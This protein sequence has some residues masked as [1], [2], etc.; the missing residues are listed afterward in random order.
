MPE[1]VNAQNVWVINTCFSVVQHIFGFSWGLMGW[2][3][4]NGRGVG[5]AR[6]FTTWTSLINASNASSKHINSIA[7]GNK[8]EYFWILFCEYFW[9]K[10][11]SEVFKFECYLSVIGPYGQYFFEYFFFGFFSRKFWPK[12]GQKKVLKKWFRN[13]Q[14]YS[15]FHSKA[16]TKVF[17]SIQMSIQKNSHF[18]FKSIQLFNSKVFN[19]SIQKY[20]NI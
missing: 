18:E 20:S 15:F 1:N 9:V 3:D 6:N 2:A 7:P 17:K 16:F 11:P 19:Y 8:F 10:P 4:Q 13:I 14:K 12:F 5:W